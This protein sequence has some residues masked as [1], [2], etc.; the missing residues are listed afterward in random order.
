[1]SSLYLVV[2]VRTSSLCCCLLVPTN[3]TCLLQHQG[4]RLRHG[5]RQ[6]MAYIILWSLGNILACDGVQLIV[7]INFITQLITNKIVCTFAYPC[8]NCIEVTG[9]LHSELLCNTFAYI[10]SRLYFFPLKRNIDIIVEIFSCDGMVH[11]KWERGKT[12]KYM[13]V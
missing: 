8:S 3:S 2:L 12:V 11:I 5:E 4:T 9:I 1:M 6:V 10:S 7:I 13:N